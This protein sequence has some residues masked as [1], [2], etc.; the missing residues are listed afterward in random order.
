M[1]GVMICR[2]IQRAQD[3]AAQI[4]GEVQVVEL[5]ELN[6]GTH[7]GACCACCVYATLRSDVVCAC[8]ACS[9]DNN[10][11]NMF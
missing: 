1:S 11:H 2:S 3:L 8:V 10:G 5:E 4:E 7:A 6:Q 9:I